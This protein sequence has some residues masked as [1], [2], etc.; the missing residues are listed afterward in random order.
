MMRLLNSCPK[1]FTIKLLASYII[2]LKITRKYTKCYLLSL[3]HAILLMTDDTAIIKKSF[4]CG[5]NIL[6]RSFMIQVEKEL[7]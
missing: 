4:C 6:D 1:N 7:V 5:I 3:W 2:L